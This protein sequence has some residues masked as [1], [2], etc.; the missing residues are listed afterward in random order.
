M[1]SP[2]VRPVARAPV[3]ILMY[4]VIAEPPDDAPLPE[5]FVSPRDFVGQMAWLAHHGFH[6]ATL[7]AV[8]DSWHGGRSLPPRAIVITFDDGY[9]SAV[10]TALPV[11]ARRG[12][13][14]VLNL[15]VDHLR[16][17]G[18]RPRGIRRLI[19]ARWEIDA[20]TITH[21]DLTALRGEALEREVA[22][23][24][25]AIRR[26]FGVPVDFFCYPSGRY[27]ASVITAVR[28]AGF[29]GATTTEFGLARP[30]E[31]FTLDR[32]RVSGSDGID[33]FAQKLTRLV[34]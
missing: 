14:G 23:S 11:L 16:S 12:W 10:S 34:P 17:S 1:P 28:R 18:I 33:G 3:P 26:A 6:A 19:H 15:T 25:T 29:L 2:T 31:P 21:A 5:L 22:G 32:V 9:R 13:P 24:R 4:H 30:S 20:H 27:D 8:W 7:R